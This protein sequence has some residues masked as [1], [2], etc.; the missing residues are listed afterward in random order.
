[1]LNTIDTLLTEEQLRTRLTS[2]ALQIAPHLKADPVLVGLFKGAFVFTADL[3]RELSR[4]G[5]QPTLDFMVLSSYGKTMESS[6][7]VTVLLE[8]R[9]NLKNRQVLLIDDIL[10]SGHTL[11]FASR[12][13]TSK[14]AKEVLTCVLLDKPER[15]KIAFQADFVGFTIPN[16]FVVGFGIDYAERFRELPYIGTIPHD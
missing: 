15:R 9:E 11:D 6:G 13:L 4:L 8:C 5:V 3:V 1:M 14:G 2:L 7:Q 12:H 16:L 10:D